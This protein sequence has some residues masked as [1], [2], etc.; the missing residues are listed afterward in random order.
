MT[1][2][3]LLYRSLMLTI[4]LIGI[5][6][7]KA[8]PQYE[9]VEL[10]SL[11]QVRLYPSPFQ[12]AQEVD[13]KYI[14]EMDVDRLLAPYMQEAGLD[15]AAERYG[16]WEDTG[17]D[18]HIGGHYLSAL[19]MMYASTGDLEMKRRMDYMVESLALAQQKNGNGYVGGIPGGMAMW[20][21]IGRGE[22]DA[23]GFSLNQ[24][25]V[26]L[27]NIHKI[28]AGLRDAYLIGGN[29]Q[30][31]EVLV[32]LTEWFYALTRSL[33]DEQLQELLISEHGGLNE[34]FAD[35]AIMTGEEKYLD[36]ARKMSH[37][38]LL[39]PLVDHQDL[40]T[41]M[42]ANTQIPKVIGFQRIALATGI[43]SWHEASDFFWH[44]V[45]ENRT[46]AIGGNS[47]REHFHPI[48]DFSS[49]MSSNQGPETCNTYNMLRLT[50]QLF[51]AQPSV[52]Y[53]DF[54]ERGLYNHILSSQHPVRGGF[55]YFTPMRPEH[56]RVYSQAHE[57][58]W[59]C[60]GSGLEN[61]AKYGEF[62]YAHTREDLYVNLFIPSEL[63]WAD[64]G[65]VLKQETDFPEK[66]KSTFHFELE[67]SK[68]INLLM[69]YPSWVPEGQLTILLN[70]EVL[71]L[72]QKPGSYVS[73][74]RIWDHKDK[75]E[76][77]MPMTMKWETLP[78]GS[79]W[80]AFVY[81]PIVL[82]AEAGTYDM[83][84]LLADGSRM[85][86]IAAGKM[87]PLAAVPLL[88]AEKEQALQLISAGAE[89]LFFELSQGEDHDEKFTL[90]PFYTIHDA[91]YQVYWPLAA[92]GMEAE[93][94][95]SF[96]QKDEWMLALD[97]E[98]VDQVATGEQQPESDH[99]FQGEKT[100]SGNENGYFWRS[101]SAWFSYELKN[102]R[103]EGRKLRLTFPAKA[104]KQPF[105]LYLNETLFHTILL[106]TVEGESQELDLVLPD[107]YQDTDKLKITFKAKPGSQIEKIYYIR[108]MK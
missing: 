1:F 56:Y 59:C 45:T 103:L 83:P 7:E 52:E 29:E 90:K 24:K 62:I 18:G 55:V 63:D 57:G 60:V 108:L 8:Y 72:D 89:P 68:R 20:E 44:T 93:I 96:N 88:T 51:M 43:D 61:H 48:D 40:L 9:Q 34:T 19:A 100:L 28:F 3:P 106:D 92:K 30:A 75:L 84:G 67:E 80:G 95:N 35:V 94:R 97:H 99:F 102:P 101:G 11:E 69:R 74:D 15:W 16:N 76:V 66:E 12:N 5:G 33:S 17:L 53:V 13:R 41:S 23:G 85:G 37:L 42:H 81:G 2:S 49:M 36:L 25:W 91:R 47:V 64:M 105:E 10:F 22:I 38:L 31:R 4:S 39:E 6:L 65:L 14:L 46:V 98:T 86:H 87:R 73:I 32:D 77:Q 104:Q 27:Y 54:Y 107:A 58:F 21:Q 70:G 82:A 50:E 26:P 71:P 78:D 79:D